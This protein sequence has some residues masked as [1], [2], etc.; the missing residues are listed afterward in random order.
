MDLLTL[1]RRTFVP[2]VILFGR[3]AYGAYYL[4]DRAVP[5]DTAERQCSSQS[6]DSHLATIHSDADWQ[7]VLAL[8]EPYGSC[9]IGLQCVADTQ[10]YASEFSTSLEWIDG[11]E[12]D[13]GFVMNGVGLDDSIWG[14]GADVGELDEHRCIAIRKEPAIYRWDDVSCDDNALFPI[15]E[16]DS[17]ATTTRRPT[18]A[19]SPATPGFLCS[20]SLEEDS[21]ALCRMFQFT[22]IYDRSFVYEDFA[23]DNYC[24]WCS[25]YVQCA[26]CEEDDDEII[27]IDFSTMNDG[28]GGV[29]NFDEA[30]PTNL[31]TLDISA[32][33]YAKSKLTGEWDWSRVKR[34]TSLKRLAISYHLFTGAIGYQDWD[35][36]AE[37]EEFECAGCLFEGDLSQFDDTRPSALRVL[38]LWDTT[39]LYTDD[40][41][42]LSERGFF[43]HLPALTHFKL[44]NSKVM[45]DFDN[46]DAISNDSLP[47]LVEFQIPTN[48]FYG[49]LAFSSALS[50]LPSN[51]EV[52][53]VG[54]NA[55]SGEVQWQ[56]FEDLHKLRDLFLVKNCLEGE[57]E[58]EYLSNANLPEL[59]WLDLS[60]NKFEGT[61]S[62]D[63]VLPQ[64]L[65]RFEISSNKFDGPI[66]WRVFVLSNLSVLDLSANNFSDVIQWSTFSASALQ[67]LSLDNNFFQGDIADLKR[68]SLPSTLHELHIQNN[69]LYGSVP[70][71]AICEDELPNLTTLDMS[72][73]QLT[74]ALSSS[75]DCDFPA[76]MES[77]VLSNNNFSE[78][79]WALFSG[80]HS[81]VHLDLERNC[82]SGNIDW[83]IIGDL[84]Q[85]G[86][87]ED[88]YLA[89]NEFDGY[90]DFSW[91]DDTARVDISIDVSVHCDPSVYHLCAVS[92]EGR[93]KATC[94]SKKTCEATCNCATESGG[95]CTRGLDYFFDGTPCVVTGD[96]HFLPWNGHRHDFQGDDE[97]YYVTPCAGS[98]H[99]DLPFDIVGQHLE[100]GESHVSGLQYLT[101]VL[102]DDNGDTLLL[103]MNADIQSFTKANSVTSTLYSSYNTAALTTIVPNEIT[104]MG[105]RFTLFFTQNGASIDASLSMD[106]CMVSFWMQGQL[107]NEFDRYTSHAVVIQPPSCYRCHICGLCG[108]F[109]SSDEQMQSCYGFAMPYTDGYS[110]DVAFAYDINGN[111]W[112]KDYR[113]EHCAVGEEP[114]DINEYVSSVPENFVY[115][116]PC[117]ADM[118][119]VVRMACQ[120][121]RDFASECCE[122]IGG[123]YCDEMQTAC[124]I[125]VCAQ[126]N[127]NAEFIIDAVTAL[128][129]EPVELACQIPDV[130]EVFDEAQNVAVTPIPTAPTSLPTTA[131]TNLPSTVPTVIPTTRS[132][133]HPGELICGSQA[134]G[135]YT[136]TAVHI[137]VRMPYAGNMTLDASASDFEIDTISA[138][139]SD[140]G[141]ALTAEDQL[142]N[143]EAHVSALTLNNLEAGGD[144]FF[145]LE[146]AAN[147]TAGTFDVVIICSSDSPTLSPTREPTSMPTHNPT[148]SPTANPTTNPSANPTTNSPTTYSPT[149]SKPSTSPTSNPTANPSQMPTAQPSPLPTHPGE[150]TCGSYADATFSGESVTIMVRMPYNGDMTV[151]ASYSDFPLTSIIAIDSSGETLSNV[152]VL[153]AN[154]L[155]AHNLSAN[156]DYNFVFSGSPD[157]VGTFQVFVYCSSDAPTASPTIKPTHSP[158]DIG[159]LT[160]DSHVTGQY[161]GQPIEI[162]VRMPYDGD[163]TVDAFAS[164]FTIGAIWGYD[165]DENELTNVDAW[166]STLT[167][168]DLHANEDYS[169]LLAGADGV[170]E[171]TFDISIACWSHGPT[172]SPTTATDNSTTDRPATS[173]YD[174]TTMTSSTISTS[175]SAPN[176]TATTSSSTSTS[177]ASTTLPSATDNSS[178]DRPATTL[179]GTTTTLTNNA[180]ITTPST[181]LPSV[182]IPNPTTTTSSTSTTS[183]ST[184][185]PSSSSTSM[186]PTPQPTTA[187]PTSAS[188]TSSTTTVYP[189]LMHCGGHHSGEFIGDPV[190]IDVIMGFDGDM[191]FDASGSDF[192]IATITAY[193]K[194][195]QNVKL[196]DADRTESK[197]TVHG[198]T[199][200][201]EY[202]FLLTGAP[203]TRAYNTEHGTWSVSIHCEHVESQS[204]TP[205]PTKKWIASKTPAPTK[206]QFTPKTPSPTKWTYSRTCSQHRDCSHL[207][208]CANGAC[209]DRPSEGDVCA[210]NSDCKKGQ[211]CDSSG[212]CVEK[213]PKK[214]PDYGKGCCVAADDASQEQSTQ[215]F[216]FGNDEPKCQRHFADGCEWNSQG[217]DC[218]EE[219]ANR[220]GC[221]AATKDAEN[222]FAPTCHDTLDKE[223]CVGLEAKG[224]EWRTGEMAECAHEEKTASGEEDSKDEKDN[225]D[226]CC[227]QTDQ[228]ASDQERELCTKQSDCD[229][230][231]ELE[232][233]GCA[234]TEGDDGECGEEESEENND[235][236]GCCVQTYESASEWEVAVCTKQTD[237]DS[238]D[239]LVE[240]GCAWTKGDEGECAE[241][242]SD[243]QW[244]GA[245]EYEQSGTAKTA[246]TERSTRQSRW[247]DWLLL[248][249]MTV[250][251]V[252]IIYRFSKAKLSNKYNGMMDSEEGRPLLRDETRV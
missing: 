16:D 58:W 168:H 200:H 156:G 202:Y 86:A 85:K 195:N 35:A 4:L 142:T 185:P 123:T 92:Q 247:N 101:F 246:K 218:V 83:D 132:P 40:A 216:A 42:D 26:S 250:T 243:V 99:V 236:K 12:K 21:K 109:Q 61:I 105:S 213:A 161:K 38:N 137:E 134:S 118:A 46:L 252:V 120:E 226:G 153:I 244:F 225:N 37:L 184:T 174:A 234:W 80:L 178:T 128:F 223:K 136:G 135:D 245:S 114:D 164:D 201:S 113:D 248:L 129:I 96:P 69:Q 204:P 162:E 67:I 1:S 189:G 39:N 251:P 23:A 233:K 191:I 227:V 147:V 138:Y 220:N 141:G 139:D 159:E 230:C 53:H 119:V 117:D 154:V 192:A 34:I 235:A 188:P 203:L 197:L 74:G 242:E 205:A 215:C 206:W 79:D 51:L 224:C 199:A 190:R 20:T 22:D 13:F 98:D 122:L 173:T 157:A 232:A 17:I 10:T 64:K 57:P 143:V 62:G 183:A 144:Y 228:F 211:S 6:P 41:L 110:A 145:V 125:D 186:I 249:L 196:L 27:S 103:F 100:W 50:T 237:C 76:T 8:C 45:G 166:P 15:C 24:S 149:T 112:Q 49:T 9:W 212:L 11:S 89:E 217:E 130:A 19:P 63:L 44:Y 108:D 77:L 116:D 91:I 56:I 3:A 84:H 131:P 148:Q 106:G 94:S 238:C 115:V 171:G 158:T 240:K 7:E 52:F 111:T 28:L 208:K 93:T 31:E 198:L 182:S 194:Q 54:Y 151:D 167:A 43:S 71:D 36:I 68:S 126:I 14:P 88:L 193:D 97:Y 175:A 176:S 146:G 169:F 229:A 221:C 90:V 172:S 210:Q 170:S 207:Q 72:S 177:S 124:E 179:P 165:S 209:V 155:T 81:L 18:K 33:I 160:C 29:L 78:V 127:G 150:L 32:P 133:T 65:Q 87:L 214:N 48:Y 140:F 107:T 73:N 95:S 241:E 239:D 30:W 66:M 121:V 47:D 187:S 102:Y 163:L 70:W 219:T 59:R 60:R 25:E 2:S 231:D 181:T 5:F 222:D 104:P 82:L 180:T 152:D 55:F 75:S